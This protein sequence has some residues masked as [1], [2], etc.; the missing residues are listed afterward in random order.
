MN[1]VWSIFAMCV[2]CAVVG[3]CQTINN[4]KDEEARRKQRHGR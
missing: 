1:F 2:F 3:I 4:Q